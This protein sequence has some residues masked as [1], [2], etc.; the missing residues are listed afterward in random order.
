MF[1]IPEEGSVTMCID[2]GTKVNSAWNNA[3]SRQHSALSE[4]E[5]QYCN[6]VTKQGMQ[7]Y[8]CKFGDCKML[9]LGPSM[10]QRHLRTHTGEK[11]FHCQFCDFKSSRKGNLKD[12]IF[13]KHSQELQ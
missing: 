9:I 11:P 5:L 3:S 13:R 7:V 10:F 2:A 1:I 12:H 8:A 6:I 4:Q